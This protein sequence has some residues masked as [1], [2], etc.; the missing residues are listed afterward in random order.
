[1]EKRF[2]LFIF[3]SLAIL[4]VYQS[5]VV[6][7]V[8]KPV[9]GAT[10]ASGPTGARTSTAN[11]AA[12]AAPAAQPSAQPAPPPAVADVPALVGDTSERDVTVETRDVV[13]VFTNRGARLK[14]WRLKHYRDHDGQPQELIEKSLP[15]EPL[16]FTVH[17]DSS[18]VNAAVNNALFT[19]SGERAG[20][21][22][23]PV[24]LR[25]EFRSSSGVA[26]VKEFHLQPASYVLTVTTTITDGDKALAPALVWGPAVGD[27]AEIS[28]YTQSPEAI[29]FAAGKVQR[30]AASK[31]AAQPKYDGDF[32]LAG[33][34]DNYFLTAA[35]NVR[36]SSVEY[37]T[38]SVP[39]PSGSKDPPRELVSYT[40]SPR[41][42]GSPLQYFV[43]PK[44]FDVLQGVDPALT[45]AIHF[46]MF[47]FI[48][49][50]LL[51]SLKGVHEYVPN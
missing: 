27:V 40:V 4:T 17:T 36:N 35:L 41:A 24:D 1:M 49:V 50:P 37:R 38:V 11:A 23:S 18:A 7:P 5:L 3:L 32:P 44:D 39:P 46:G 2:L 8:P 30:V 26:A 47:Q 14:S 10:A 25:F 51:K 6:K 33:V 43:G 12:P 48:V 21:V 42:A 20:V 9:P 45:D 28:R 13:A 16:P 31:I 22:D 19:V 29:L 15:N 34:D